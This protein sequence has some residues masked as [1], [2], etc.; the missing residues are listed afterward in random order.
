MTGS[1]LRI[2]MIEADPNSRTALRQM[3]AGYSIQNDVDLQ[4]DWVSRREQMRS[5]PKLAVDAQIALVNVELGDLALK[6]GEAVA[7]HNPDCLLVYF[8]SIQVDLNHLLAARPVA[9]Q[10]RSATADEWHSL[11]NRLREKLLQQQCFSWSGKSNQVILPYRCISY[12]QSDRM[13]FDVHTLSGTSY[14]LPG[15]LDEVQKRLPS[16]VFLRVHKSILVNQLH[17]RLLDKGRKCLVMADNAEIH[18]SKV[19]YQDVVKK[20][21]C[22]TGASCQQQEKQRTGE[23]TRQGFQHE[24]IRMFCG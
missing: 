10:N 14:R 5:L 23:G 21:R 16:Q 24:Q 6:A 8:G 22:L 3:L 11:L 18:I 9:Y 2:L 12:I 19:H 1:E 4:I 13:H 15:R 17:I 20:V 7:A